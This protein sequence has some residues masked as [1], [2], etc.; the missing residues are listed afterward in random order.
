MDVELAYLRIL[1][2]FPRTA[3]ALLKGKVAKVKRGLYG[4][5]SSCA[6]STT[7]KAGGETRYGTY[8]FGAKINGP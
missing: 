2:V 8:G 7:V 6:S 5:A 3:R 4:S 1:S